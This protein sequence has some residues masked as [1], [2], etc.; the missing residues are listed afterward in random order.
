[1][2][3]TKDMLARFPASLNLPMHSAQNQK[4]W[5]NTSRSFKT[6]P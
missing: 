4:K 2:F 1:M 6:S 5:A 3:L